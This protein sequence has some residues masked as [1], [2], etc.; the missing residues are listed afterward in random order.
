MFKIRPKG[1][2]NIHFELFND[3]L[4]EFKIRPQRGRQK[5][6]LLLKRSN[7]SRVSQ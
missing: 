7:V 6:A 3:A 4:M 2:G 1:D 5:E